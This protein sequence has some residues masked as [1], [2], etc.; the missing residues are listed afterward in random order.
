MRRNDPRHV[1]VLVLAAD[2]VVAALQGVLVELAG[3]TPA[4]ARDGERP[5]ESIARLRPPAVVLVDATLEATRSDVFLAS[6]ARARVPMATF[7]TPGSAPVL[8][9]RTAGRGIPHLALPF[10]VAELEDAL[11]EAQEAEWWVRAAER[12]RGETAAPSPRERQR[13]S[14]EFIFHD[15]RGRRWSV[16][17]RRHAERRR[18][19][20]RVERV[21]VSEGGEVRTC[22][23]A[24]D[25]V[26]ARRPEQLE[27]QLARAD[28]EE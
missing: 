1:N 22:T 2:P 20:T 18:D 17:D 12:R 16:Y 13:G 21:F 23:L 3:G 10:T 7:E 11:R 4:F 24:P 28:V 5:E 6:A 26:S 25:E 19:E 8:G 9:S 14:D 15:R 27:A